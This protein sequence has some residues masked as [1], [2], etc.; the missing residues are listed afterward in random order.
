MTICLHD[1]L[2]SSQFPSD[3]FPVGQ[4]TLWTALFKLQYRYSKNY[5]ADLL[6]IKIPLNPDGIVSF[7]AID[8]KV[9][10]RKKDGLK[11][12]SRS[13]SNAL[14]FQGCDT[15]ISDCVMF[16]VFSRSLML[17]AECTTKVTF[18]L[19]SSQS[20]CKPNAVWPRIHWVLCACL[21]WISLAV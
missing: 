9:K 14:L 8:G 2:F 17:T 20:L 13:E 1:S 4:H 19:Y 21:L 3:F 10:R 11:R 15:I 18:T 12:E 5:Q 16:T 7:K 6:L